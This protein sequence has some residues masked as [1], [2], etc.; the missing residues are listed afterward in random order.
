MAVTPA[1]TGPVAILAGGGE[2]PVLVAR[3]AVARGRKVLIVG[4]EEEAETRI[5]Q[6]EH[7]WIRR[8]QLGKLFS[9][10]KRAGIADLVMIGGMRQRRMPRLSEIDF[11][12]VWTVI[13][14]IG[15]LWR[16]DDGVLRIIARIIEANGVRIVGAADVA[17]ELTVTS[18][19]LTRRAPDAADWRD[20]L[21]AFDAA[22]AHGERDRGQGAV[23]SGGLVLMREPAEGTDAMLAEIAGDRLVDGIAERAG[24]LVKCLKPRQDRRLDMPAIGPR[25]AEGVYIAG[26]KG[27]AVEAG[28]TLV[29][30]LAGLVAALDRQGLFL[31]G[32]TPEAI[33]TARAGS[34]P[35][36]PE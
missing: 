32:L 11:G 27:I 16:G 13:R 14:H 25:T 26:L 33:A 4:I 24:V 1:G 2:F 28:E 31:V 3:A 18:G 15:L 35:G 6:F 30:D 19:C 7:V 17:P 21:V 34:T 36:R 5:E 23:A 22:K 20:I 12:G 10:L 29:A 8:G 9:S